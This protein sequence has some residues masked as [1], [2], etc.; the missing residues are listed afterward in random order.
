[1]ESKPLFLFSTILT[2]AALFACFP[3]TAASQDND[4]SPD[5]QTLRALLPDEG[6]LS[7]LEEAS[8]PAFYIPANLWEYINGQSELYLQYGFRQVITADFDHRPSS[9]SLAAEIYQMLSPHHAFGIYAA[10]RSPDDDYV[11]VGVQGYSGSNILNF[12]KGPY[13]IKLTAYKSSPEVRKLLL[14]VARIIEGNITGKYSEPDLF[15]CFPGKYRVG[16]SERFIPKNFM[17][18]S[19]LENGYRVDYEKEGQRYQ[20]VLAENSTSK[21]AV[22]AFGKYQDFLESQSEVVTYERGPDYQMIKV[23]D[24]KGKVM[25]QYGIF[26]GGILGLKDRPG[27]E[28][29]VGE[30]IVCLKGRK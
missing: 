6:K 26:V 10:E 14:E 5:Q 30:V 24:G 1:M 27:G 23:G 12:W 29:L 4:L 25:F 16:M 19:F 22:E 3:T 11:K 18:H 20:V 17:G 8:S 7:D 13:Y 28:R 21:E 15:T 9:T 2:S